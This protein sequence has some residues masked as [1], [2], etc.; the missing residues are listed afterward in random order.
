MRRRP[1]AQAPAARPAGQMSVLAPAGPVLALLAVLALLLA[2]CAAGGSGADASGPATRAERS[3]AAERG[4]AGDAPDVEPGSV[5]VGGAE[6]RAARRDA[7]IPACKPA[8]AADGTVADGGL[9]DVTLPCLGGGPG[10][11][12][13]ALRGPLVINLWASWCAPC[14]TEL[15]HFAR[16]H[17]AGVDVLG[18]DFQEPRPDRAIELAA[19][20]GVAYPLVADVDG[21]LRAPLRITALPTTLFVDERGV[22]TAT[23][24]QE[25]SSYG[26]LV[27]AVE[28]H[29]GVSP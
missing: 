18:V 6:L 7:G 3:A 2:S 4:S 14:R 27:A 20:T 16:L 24:T 21:R 26:E 19:D 1:R 5:E 23:L 12:L 15:P 28:R 29:L 9:P 11:H 10:I 17:T 22:V 25:F 13:A 8:P